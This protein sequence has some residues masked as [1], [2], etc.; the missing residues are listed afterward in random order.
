MKDALVE[1]ERLLWE[2]GAEVHRRYVLEDAVL[3]LDEHETVSREEI[4]TLLER[5]DEEGLRWFNLS[6][7][8]TQCVRLDNDAAII[9]YTATGNVRGRS[10]RLSARCKSLYMRRNG[11]FRVAFHEHLTAD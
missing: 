9:S 11:R 10:A 6:F 5:M 7:E 3:V 1:V 8:D 4:I 2:S